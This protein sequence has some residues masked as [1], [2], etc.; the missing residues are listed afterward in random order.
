MTAILKIEKSPYIGDRLTDCHEILHGDA[1][2]ASEPHRPLRLQ[3]F[4]IQGGGR[5]SS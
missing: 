4:K 1:Q 2:R 3:F 5:P